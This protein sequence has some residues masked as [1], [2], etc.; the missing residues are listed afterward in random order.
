MI[1]A[2]I[3][4]AVAANRNFLEMDSLIIDSIIAAIKNGQAAINA[5][6][7]LRQRW[8]EG[9]EI[10]SGRGT[11]MSVAATVACRTEMT[12]NSIATIRFVRRSLLRNRTSTLA[13]RQIS[14][15]IATII[16]GRE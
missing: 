12:K 3:Q 8:Y 6:F 10:P 7:A 9:R 11:S 5:A 2:T 13:H 15:A 4:I 1:P 16:G 14:P